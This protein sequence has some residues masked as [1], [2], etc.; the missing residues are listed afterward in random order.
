MNSR[1]V[2]IVTDLVSS[3]DSP[4]LGMAS[5]TRRSAGMSNPDAP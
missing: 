1:R 3:A 2:L 4:C 5:V